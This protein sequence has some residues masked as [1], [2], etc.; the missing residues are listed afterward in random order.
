MQDHNRQRA[1]RFEGKKVGE[2]RDTRFAAAESNVL[3]LSPS[4][5]LLFTG[6]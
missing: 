5:L 2:A 1:R 3:T 4:Q 6:R